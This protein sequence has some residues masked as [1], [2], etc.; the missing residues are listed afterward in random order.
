M[1]T[2]ISYHASTPEQTV[3][4]IMRKLTPERAAALVDFARFL[5]Y[6]AAEGA[7]GWPEADRAAA[8]EAGDPDQRWDE[9]LA[10]PEAKEVMRQMAREAREDFYAGRTTEIVDTEDGRLT[11][12]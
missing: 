5:E 3:I 9:L 2:Q 8:G 4:R 7:G 1:E 11:P 12:G 6:R 10:R